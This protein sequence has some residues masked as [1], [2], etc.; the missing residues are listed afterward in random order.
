MTPTPRS[1]LQKNEINGFLVRE[2]M[3]KFST[4]VNTLIL[5]VKVKHILGVLCTGGGALVTYGDIR[6]HYENWLRSVKEA[7]VFH[8]RG[9]VSSQ[10][11]ACT[12]HHVHPAADDLSI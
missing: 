11:T 1:R 9:A 6:L 4:F 10:I 5:F 12:T 7:R 3:L 2:L 8:V